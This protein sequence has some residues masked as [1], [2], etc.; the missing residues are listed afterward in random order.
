MEG[1]IDQKLFICPNVGL[2]W[3]ER[4]VLKFAHDIQITLNRLLICSQVPVSEYDK[5]DEK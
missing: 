5:L 4:S 2:F 1:L 3:S